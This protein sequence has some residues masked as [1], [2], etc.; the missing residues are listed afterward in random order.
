M[1]LNTKKLDE[2]EDIEQES[3]IIVDFKYDN[4]VAQFCYV[5]IVYATK[6]KEGN[7]VKSMF[8]WNDEVDACTFNF[9]EVELHDKK[10]DFFIKIPL[11]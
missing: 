10:S 7:I 1:L 8:N 11:N 6:N 3:R 4:G 9:N 5:R 2:E